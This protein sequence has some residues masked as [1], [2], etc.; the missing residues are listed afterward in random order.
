MKIRFEPQTPFIVVHERHIKAVVD[1]IRPPRFDGSLV[2]AQPLR[3]SPV[4]ITLSA[5]G[6]RPCKSSMAP[7]EYYG[8]DGKRRLCDTL[9]QLFNTALKEWDE[10]HPGL[11]GSRR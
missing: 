6:N 11:P 3:D 7:S 8:A 2:V 9:M 4:E 5:E 1:A 10:K